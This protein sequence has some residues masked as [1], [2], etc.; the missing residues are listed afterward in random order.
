MAFPHQED[1]L[2]VSSEQLPG[3]GWQAFADPQ[4]LTAWVSEGKVRIERRR[5]KAPWRP[6]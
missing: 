5:L 4:V 1:R 2:V 3:P 6:S